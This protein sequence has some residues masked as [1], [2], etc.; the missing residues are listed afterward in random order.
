MRYGYV[1]SNA[2]TLIASCLDAYIT[3]AIFSIP[4]KPN[5]VKDIVRPL[6][7]LIIWGPYMFLSKRVRNTFIK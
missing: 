1:G 4:F 3:F 7:T 5:D 6:L 2:L